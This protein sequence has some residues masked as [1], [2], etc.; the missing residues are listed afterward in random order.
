MLEVLNRYVHGYVAIPVILSCHKK[1]L[2]DLLHCFGPLTLID[3]SRQLNANMGHMQVALQLFE[4]LRWVEKNKFGYYSILC[5]PE[6]YESLTQIPEYILSLYQSP[7][8]LLLNKHRKIL[9]K[10]LHAIMEYK[11]NAATFVLDF[12]PGVVVVPLLIALKKNYSQADTLFFNKIPSEL[13]QLILAFFLEKKW[14]EQKGE[15]IILTNAGQ[16]MLERAYNMATAASYAPM[17]ANISTLLFGDPKKV[18][19]KNSQG[20]E[21]HIDRTLNV[22]ASGFQHI[23]YFDDVMQAVVTI[24][25][26]TPFDKQPRYVID[27][28]CGDGTL[29]SKIY[30]LICNQSA[31]GAVLN[32]YPLHMIGV[33]YNE[34]S[35]AATKLTLQAIPHYTLHGD[36]GNP[37]K[38]MA[39]LKELGIVDPENCLHVRSFL[40]HDRPYLAPKNKKNIQDRLILNYQGAYVDD[41]GAVIPAAEM[42]QSLVEHLSRWSSIITHHGLLLLEV[43]NLLAETVYSYIDENESLH[44]DA[45][46][47]FSK[48]YLVEADVFLLS[49]AEVGLFPK[50]EFS[51]RYPSAFPY[52]RITLNYFEKRDYTL[53]HAQAADVP[54]LLQLEEACWGKKLAVSAY[55]IN[56][57]LENFP[58][59][60]LIVKMHDRIV[61]VVYTQKIQSITEL[62]D[63]TF[64]K[65]SQLHHNAGK[66]IQLLGINVLPEMQDTGLG[67][68]LREFVLWWA[69]LKSGIKTIVGITRCKNYVENSALTMKE[70]I[71]QHTQTAGG[72]DLILRFHT[73]HGAQIKAI[74]KNYRPEDSDNQ[75][76]GILIEYDL[77][78]LAEPSLPLTDAAVVPQ[79]KKVIDKNIALTVNTLI[80]KLI[81]EVH[82][83]QYSMS[84]P[85][86]E[87]GLDSLGLL[88]LRTLINQQFNVKLDP[89]F[90][91]EYNTANAI[92]EYLNQQL[93]DVISPSN[94]TTAPLENS[95]EKNEPIAI[96]GMSCR[97]PGGVNSSADFWELLKDG[98]NAITPIPA[99]RKKWLG[100]SLSYGGFLTDIDCFDADFFHISPREAEVMDP[101]QRILLEVTW[102]ALEHAGICADQLNNTKTGVFVGIFSHDYETLLTK[103]KQNKDLDAYYATGNS[104]SV[105]AG[106]LAY[107]LGL[108]GPAMA[109]D[110]ACSSSLVAVHLACQS[111]R[112]NECDIAIAGGVNLILSPEL[113]IAFTNA[114]MLSPVGKCKTFDVS[115]DGY[116]RSEGCGVLIVKKLA[117]ALRDNDT[118][119]AIIR[120]SAINQDGKSNGLTAPSH[121]AQAELL[122]DAL[123][124]ANITANTVNYLETHGTGTSLGDP[125]EVKAIVEVYRPTRGLD[126]PLVLGS[127]KTNIGHTEAAAGMAG[128]FKTILMLQQQ[129]IPGILHFAQLNPHILLDTPYFKFPTELMPWLP[130]QQFPRRAGVSSF[131]FSGT[132][133]HIILEESPAC[134]SVI[135][136]ILKPCYLFTFSAKN[137]HALQNKILQFLA[138]FKNN[139]SPTHDA[140][141]L[142]QISYTLNL[143]RCHFTYRFA[144][145]ASTCAEL[146]ASLENISHLGNDVAHAD[147]ND[148]IKINAIKRL[149][150]A[151]SAPLNFSVGEYRMKLA[152]LAEYYI[153]GYH[154]DWQTLHHNEAKKR[155]SLPVYPFE[156][157]H[158]WYNSYQAAPLAKIKNPLILNSEQEKTVSL[159]VTP[160]GIAIVRMLDRVGK[161]QLSFAFLQA[162]EN[163]FIELSHNPAVKVAVLT[164]YDDVF[165]LGGSEEVLLAISKSEVKYTDLSFLYR[166]LL[167]CPIPVISA[168][169]GHAFGAGLAFGLY[170]DMVI[171]AENSLF[172]A[173]FMNYGFTPGVGSTLIF[174]EKLSPPLAM[175]MMWTAKKYSGLELKARGATVVFKN[176]SDVFSEAMMLATTFTT[177][178]M[179]ALKIFKRNMTDLLLE[180]LSKTIERELQMHADIFA[181]PEATEIIKNYFSSRSLA[182]SS[183]KVNENAGIILQQKMALEDKLISPTVL[184]PKLMLTPTQPIVTNVQKDV[185]DDLMQIIAAKLHIAADR[186]DI[187]RSFKE[188]GV[189]SINAV[190]IVR[191][192]GQ[193]FALTIEAAMIYD[194]PTIKQFAHYLQTEISQHSPKSMALE[195]NASLPTKKIELTHFIPETP[196]V[197]N[198]VNRDIAIIGFS[199]QFPGAP[200]VD[201]FWENLAAGKSSIT[202]IP[203]ERWNIENFYD[204]NI[205]VPNRSNSKW[206]GFLNEIDQFDPLFFGMSPAEAEQMDPQQRL[207]LQEAWKVFEQAGYSTEALAGS[208]CA[209]FVGASVGDYA[210]KIKQAGTDS[211]AHLL[212]GSNSSILA[213]RIS[214]HLDLKG[215]SV[216]VDTACSSSL[217]AIHQACQSLWSEES[218]MALA[219]GVCIL[220][221]AEMHIMTSK[222]GMLSTAGLC[223]TFDDTADGFVPGEAVGVVLLKPLNQAIADKDIIYGVIKGSGINQDGKTNGITAPCMKAQTALELDVY[224]RFNINPQTIS[225]VEAH[226]TGTKLG[227]PIEVNALTRAFRVYTDNNQ[228][229]AIGSVKTNIG[230][231]LLAAGVAGLIKILLCL[232]HK[233]LVPTLNYKQQNEHINFSHSPFYVNTALKDWEQASAH[234][235]RAALSSFGLSGTNAHMIIEEAPNLMAAVAVVAEKPYYLVTLSAK[236]EKALKQRIIDLANYLLPAATT[237][238]NIAYT[239]NARKTHFPLR[240]A[241]VVSSLSELYSA[242]AQIQKNQSALNVKINYEKIKVKTEPQLED[243]LN[244]LQNTSIPADALIYHDTLL[245]LGD[246]Y[247]K[248][249][250][251]DWKKLHSNESQQLVSLPTYPFSSEKYWITPPNQSQENV[252]IEIL[253]LASNLLKIRVEDLDIQQ[254]ISEFGMDSISMS[255]FISAVNNRY[256]LNL[257]PA[258]M[259]EHATLASFIEFFF[260]NHH[261]VVKLDTATPAVKTAG[262][263]A[264]IGMSAILPGA[265]NTEQFWENLIAG[266]NVIQEI[267]PERWDWQSCYGDPFTEQGKTKAKQGGFIQDISHFDAAFF[268]ISPREA[269]LMDPQQRLFLQVVWQA[270]EDSGYSTASYAAGS[271][272]VF[273]GVVSSDYA[274]LLQN[275]NLTD[276]ATI[277]GNTRTIIANRVSYLLNLQGPSEAID[278]ACSS[279]LVAIHHAV[280]AIQNGDCDLAIAGGVNALLTPTAY[281]SASKA[282]ML[283][284]EGL[285]KTFDKNA[286]GYVRAEGVGAIIL[287]PLHKA[288]EDGDTI[289]GVIKGTAV[290]HGGHMSSLTVPNPNA[291]AD[292]ISLACRRAQIDV[293]SLTYVETHGTGTALGDPIEINGLKKAF[294]A[295]ADEK[296]NHHYY[297][298]LGSVKTNIGHL[299]S[300]AGIASVIKVLL[301]IKNKTIPGNLHFTELNPFI[302]VKDSP[303]YI[304]NQTKAWNPVNAVSGHAIPRRAGIS[305]FGFGGVNAHIVIEEAV[306]QVKTSTLRK[307]CYLITLSAKQVESL[308]LKI[309]NLLTWLRINSAVDLESLAFTLNIGRDHFKI[310]CAFVVSSVDELIAALND[311]TVNKE[312]LDTQNNN[313]SE[314]ALRYTAAMEIINQV[315]TVTPEFYQ[316]NLLILADLYVQN[317]AL[318]FK[319][320]HANE[321]CQRVASLPTYPFLTQH[322]WFNTPNSV[323]AQKTAPLENLDLHQLTLHY[324]QTLF[325]EKLKLPIEQLA[326]DATYEV[327]GVESL[328]SLE[329]T[330][331]LENDFGTLPKT[332]LY[333]K[334]K[335]NDLALYLE[336][337]YLAVLQKM[338]SSV[339]MSAKSSSPTALPPKRDQSLPTEDI[340]IIGL[341]GTYPMAKDLNAFWDNLVRGV[342]CISEVP[343]ER[344]NYKDYPVTIGN[345]THYYKHGGFIED[346]DKFDPLFFNIAPRDAALLDPQERLFIQSA[347]ATLEDAGYTRETLQRKVNNQ[348]GVF[349]GVTYNF[350]PLFIAE[351]WH[352]GNRLPLDVQLFSTANRTSYFLNLSG[353]SFVIDTAC[354]SSMAAIHLAYESILRGECQMAIAGGVNLSL[355]PSKY[356]MLGSYSL[357]SATGRC[358][359]FGANGAGYVPG[360][361]VGSVLL[362]PLSMAI[363]DNDR[364]YGVIKSSSMNHGGK[365]SG[366]T[367]PNPSAQTELIKNALNKAKCDPRT[368]N[369]IEAHGTGTALGDPIEIR[370]LQ[371]A[372][373]DYTQDKQF[374]AIGSVKSNIGHLES[375]AG[376]S[377]LTKVLLQLQ[378]KKIV[379]SLHAQELN[380]FIDFQQTPF[381]VQQELSDWQSVQGQP[382][383]AGISSFGA[384]GTNIHLIIEEFVATTQRAPVALPHLFIFLLSAQNA[385]RLK[386]HASNLLTYLSATVK[387][388]E[389]LYDL[390]Y[391][392]QTGRE[393]MAA[394]LAIAATSLADLIDKLS[395]YIKQVNPVID[396]CWYHDSVP[397]SKPLENNEKLAQA[398][399]SGAHIAWELLYSSEQKPQRIS[400]PS[401]PFAKRRCWVP[402]QVVTGLAKPNLVVEPLARND[403]WLY[404][405]YW[406]KKQLLSLAPV[407]DNKRSWLIFS[408]H[409]LGLHLQAELGKEN[410]IFCF[411]GDKFKKINSRIYFINPENLADYQ[412][413]ITEISSGNHKFLAG[414][415]YLGAFLAATENTSTSNLW[416]V[417]QYAESSKKMFNLFKALSEQQWQQEMQF[418]FVTRQSQATIAEDNINIWQH[419]LWSMT[420]IFTAECPMF[421]ALLLDLASKK[422]LT[423]DAKIITQ[424]MTQAVLGE[425]HISYRHNERYVLKLRNYLP[426]QASATWK[427]P[428]AAIITGGLGALGIEL[429]QFL[430]QQGTQYL[431]LVGTTVLPERS[432]R[433]YLTD[434]AIIEKVAQLSELEKSGITI[435]YVAADVSDKRLMQNII[436]RCEQTWGVSIDGVFHLAGVTTDNMPINKMSEELLKK[437]LQVKIQGAL[438]L[439]D[440]FNQPDVHTFVLFSSISALPYFG[441]G[442]LSAYAMANEFLNGLA[443]YRRSQKLSG[444]SINWAAWADNGMS[445][446]YN[447]IA[448]LAAIGMTSVPMA[449]GMQ[450][451]KTILTANPAIIAVFKLDWEKFLKINPDARLLTFLHDYIPQKI[452]NAASDVIVSL[453]SEEVTQLL[454]DLLAEVLEFEAAEIETTVP[455]QNYGLDS[456]L[457]V[458][459]VGKLS[460][461]FPDIVSPMDL[462]RYPTVMQLVQH[463]VKNYH[464]T[465]SMMPV[466]ASKIVQTEKQTVD[467]Y[468]PIAI[469]GVA[470]RFPEANN[471]QEYW[472]LLSSGKDVISFIPEQRWKILQD[473]EETLI[474]AEAEHCRGGFLADILSFDAYFFGITPREAVRMDPQQRLLLEVAY[475]AIEDAGLTLDALAGSAMGVFSSLYANQF[476][477]LQKINSEMDALYIPTGNATSL[478]ANRLSYLFDLRGPSIT[479]DTACSSSLVALHLA[480]LNLQNKLCDTALVSAVNLNLFPSINLL[481][482]KAKMLSPDGLCKTFDADANGYVQGEGVSAVILKPLAKALQ[483]HDRIYGVIAGSAI[484]QD[485]KTNGLT[486]PNGA[487]QEALLKAAYQAADINPSTVSYV[488]CHGTGTFLGDP[489][490]LQALGTVLGRGR[491][492]TAPCWIGSVK[493]NIGHLEPAAGLAGVIKVL[494]ALEQEKI[495]P[496]LNFSTPNP[497]INF[498]KYHLQ[499]P[500]K[501]EAWPTNQVSRIAGVSSFGFGGT[502]AHIIIRDLTETEKN[503]IILFPQDKAEEIF[504][505]SAKDATALSLLIDR[506]CIY[507]E[508]SPPV[509]LAQLCYNLHL[510]RTDYLVRLAII[511]KNIEELKQL[512]QK[513]RVTPIENWVQ[514]EK[515]LYNLQ[516]TKIEFSAA[517]PSST[518]LYFAKSY[519]NRLP[520]DWEEYET[521]R[522]YAY[523][524]MPLY[525]W[526]AKQYWPE[527]K[528]LQVQAQKNNYPFSKTKITSPLKVQQFEFEFDTRV[529][530]EIADSFNFLHA[531]YYFEML[532][533]ATHELFKQIV[534]TVEDCAFL[535][536]IFVPNNTAIKVQLV[537]QEIG[538]QCFAFNFY[539]QIT[540]EEWTENAAGNLLLAFPAQ[541]TMVAVEA[542]KDRCY[543]IGNE[544]EF[545]AKVTAMNMPSGDSIRWNKSYYFADA[546]IL[547]ELSPPKS[548]SRSESFQLNIHPGIFDSCIQ[549]LFMLLPNKFICPY[550]ASHIKRFTYY[551]INN[552]P[553]YLYATL[554]SVYFTGEKY[555]GDFYLTNDVGEV[556]A[557]CE[558]LTMTQLSRNAQLGVVDSNKIDLSL[559][560]PDVA[561]QKITDFLIEK[562]AAIFS[563]PKEDIDVRRPLRDMG[564]DSLMAIVLA[565]AIESTLGLTYSMQ[566]ILKG[567]SLF[568]IANTLVLSVVGQAVEIG[569]N[570]WI[571]NRKRQKNA[572]TRL[573]CF[574]YGGSGASIYHEWQSL[575]PDTIEVCPIQLPG[576]EDRLNEAPINDID[577]LVDALIENLQFE[578]DLPFSFFGHSF[579]S[580]LAFELARGLRKRNFPQPIQLFVS[581]FP[582]PCVPTIS[583]DRVIAQLENINLNLFDLTHMH[584]IAL[585]SDDDL[586]NISAIFSEN[587]LIEYGSNLMSPDIIKILLPI[588]SNDMCLVKSYE[589]IK[590]APLKLPITA[591]IGKKDNWVA[592]IDHLGW[593]DHTENKFEIIAFDSGHLFIKDKLIKNEVIKKITSDVETI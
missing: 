503:N 269:E 216:A 568:E 556:F 360:E 389:H 531:G 224:K 414:I 265:K 436:I 513:L 119:L 259:Y 60:Q 241:I 412:E 234:P 584:E 231:T 58:Q 20:H 540:S 549:S 512:L 266:K 290:N 2:F 375:A 592:Y 510:K 159:E 490:E 515:I 287:K 435:D 416:E 69:A 413:L 304:V 542:I 146:Q 246:L 468:E 325:A 157:E 175:E 410:C 78:N 492:S 281:L 124:S 491:D 583:L 355:H 183:N 127:V 115:A 61:A 301:A 580:L 353:P 581:A 43:H 332:L 342:D 107:V 252:N 46:H 356:H 303:F 407:K 475:E 371:E 23:R 238:E 569:A 42:V 18:F 48:Q 8:D 364:I 190:E 235:R 359:S 108:N 221:T 524:D 166:G 285:C 571:V 214:Y 589:Y 377:Q 12:L 430:L 178:S 38:I 439:H 82:R 366:Y 354:S 437:V 14:A 337:K 311:F 343:A 33:D 316:Q 507:L 406:D 198:Q 361:G 49:A 294:T 132:N 538:E 145:L 514:S 519:V 133:A 398:W 139:P 408:D 380:P 99:E 293:E 329:I 267:P 518:I 188:L 297:C 302:E 382:R 559:L 210:N 276:A 182:P 399:V 478:S 395:L 197:N 573:F 87:M 520:V 147:C 116:V 535:S 113:N 278:T 333:E 438:V 402:T 286:N 345:E 217:V 526:Q 476:S 141:Y 505:L 206:G 56:R 135:P 148:E 136:A 312:L 103:N 9:K 6:S 428:K 100:D 232:K 386:E 66:V 557:V 35:L 16:F 417:G 501:L 91:F 572:K 564:I 465:P 462:Y 508:K 263:V 385:E 305:A 474:Q 31:R 566:T 39:D 344:W 317:Y 104:T 308:K 298:D 45:Y 539:S 433:D 128:L 194:H 323:P 67:N 242:L 199:G 151:I 434:P 336:K 149:M 429:A 167:D 469:I 511:A 219:G 319:Q 279:S 309:A 396:R 431:L 449:T 394:R 453:N 62:Q 248:G 154:L 161:N 560:T 482:S 591:F 570:P 138:W 409:E 97:F 26:K 388:P 378:H 223:K 144:V 590:E 494:L 370:G 561:K 222:A 195:K 187:H 351:E 502:N 29:L 291:Q 588:F 419:H 156:K 391:T 258:I 441:I 352:K 83:Q 485:G 184:S 334:N 315:S 551:G 75:G 459:W 536:P 346:I 529:M 307:P 102:E 28:G 11:N 440:I 472:Q 537:L 487:Q 282:G 227:D 427:V 295:L 313:E 532:A 19:K 372:F 497:H 460:E 257:T 268:N 328:L 470:C 172:T 181:N 186:L 369:Y 129:Q 339:P 24:F 240:C 245:T 273:V 373:E 481:L 73:S 425:D 44:F 547:N 376:I 461:H 271:T 340:A 92:V 397:L 442:G 300:A 57:R 451:L 288:E 162:L 546:E 264:I 432:E 401:Y 365:T 270:I 327:Y 284:E 7:I 277:T 211:G 579:G 545:Y 272:G 170:A 418:C 331:R 25:N 225:Y 499:V 123:K 52:S 593:A 212:I 324:L 30:T 322:F 405:P 185:T 381:Y 201:S 463:I 443:V 105:A 256:H 163:R 509:S 203:S 350:Y 384:G 65:V 98:K 516:K 3:I 189:D 392:L 548:V 95:I 296:N 404:Q 10:S 160:E 165:C 71:N 500:T 126:F 36:V 84:Y 585:L 179:L 292:V 330:K 457:G 177:K 81:A 582:D 576:R 229:C 448:F 358:T 202:E 454:V 390:C 555:T 34:K 86:R 180:K 483:D 55:E 444:L 274:E 158:Y 553:A 558:N 506:W 534:F 543:G 109:V 563:M 466:L 552:V 169:Q 477:S 400:L 562:C 422:H 471:K 528:T 280:C 200:D 90:F 574:P 80:K 237:L 21:S 114:G 586:Y 289:Y 367:V 383:R 522:S 59:G 247:V 5:S 204:A 357:M 1:K 341:S 251:L 587:G 379:P 456:I 467:T 255:A 37:Q 96:V 122:R 228:Y 76:A 173:N 131:G 209:V 236:T 347:W 423:Q 578:F 111:L 205:D 299:E 420:R 533:I 525:P 239:L 349:V 64:A 577:I 306:K 250:D 314:L 233:K 521:G 112:N 230:H 455:L 575:F 226:G 22:M 523:I 70:Y 495:P 446:K 275:N 130:N 488:E 13:R 17:L 253:K 260:K 541:T 110:T 164:G 27:T 403:E 450:I 215:P 426:D 458:Y 125:I 480:C 363:K 496:H 374:C 530:P 249:Y 220:T 567:S 140:E 517:I 554:K 191:E 50:I 362:K 411:A 117:H 193:R 79:I 54:E 415:I 320:L 15:Q 171:M 51:R 168:I 243:M 393:N 152:S 424:E 318:N 486:A 445:F 348:V 207:F 77:F 244:T 254:K 489:I 176:A 335:L 262:D 213:S 368:I 550:V 47:A 493:T 143:G 321:K 447:H 150:S 63:I 174:Q 4:S 40:D 504:I 196:P 473:T 326:I 142:S 498:E 192:L 310:R 208:Q 41:A 484:N 93:A 283:S 32:E 387:T 464:P 137:K 101:Q 544:A 134:G 527:L 85:L 118:V 53:Q 153:E 421:K 120:G 89:T 338:F 218:T 155:L 94:T 565:S 452:I 261:S 74:L 479:L 121:V 106:R 72:V 68:Q 88:E